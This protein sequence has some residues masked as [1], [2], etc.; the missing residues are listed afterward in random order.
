MLQINHSASSITSKDHQFKYIQYIEKHFLNTHKDPLD[1]LVLGAGGFSIGS[2]DLTNRYQFV[3]IESKLQDIAQQYLLKRPLNPNVTF[4][5]KPAVN[6]LRDT[7]KQY[8]LIVVDMYSNKHAIPAQ[9]V[10]LEFYDLVKSHLTSTGTVALNVIISP[11][12]QDT[13]SRRMDNTLRTV[14]PFIYSVALHPT[15]DMSNMIYVYQP[16]GVDHAV[17]TREKAAPSIDKL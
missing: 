15:S 5:P 17:Y 10:T 7:D 6:F 4:T 16:N 1:V 14:F 9:L 12:L 8:D 13:Y 3:D 11:T 2:E